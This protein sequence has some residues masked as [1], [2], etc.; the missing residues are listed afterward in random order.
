MAII[1]TIAEEYVRETEAIVARMNAATKITMVIGYGLASPLLLLIARALRNP[2]GRTCGI[3]NRAIIATE[4]LSAGA[5]TTAWFTLG[6]VKRNIV[7]ALWVVACTTFWIRAENKVRL[8]RIRHRDTE[9][10]E[11]TKDK[12]ISRSIPAIM[13]HGSR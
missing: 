3:P 9:I 12:R 7:N 2:T 1:P 8:E 4:L 13:C 11:G 5:V 6:Q 10:T